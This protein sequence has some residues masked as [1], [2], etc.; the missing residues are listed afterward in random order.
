MLGST[1]STQVRPRRKYHSWEGCRVRPG[2]RGGWESFRG[3]GETERLTA[4]AALVLADLHIPHVVFRQSAR[5]MRCTWYSCLHPFPSLPTF[6]ESQPSAH[7]FFWSTEDVITSRCGARC[8]ELLDERDP[9]FSTM[10]G[11][12][13][14]TSHRSKALLFFFGCPDLLM[15]DERGMV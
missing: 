13:C 7:L 15:A 5:T 9:S 8:A 11:L 10:C 3:P 1:G 6:P 14:D 2:H 12:S 4:F